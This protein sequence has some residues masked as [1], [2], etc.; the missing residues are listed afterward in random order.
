MRERFNPTEFKPGVY[1]HY[2]GNLYVALHIARHHDSPDNEHIGGAVVYVGD[3][4]VV[5]Y[6]PEQKTLNVREWDT[7]G[8]DSWCDSVDL[9]NGVYV[10]RFEYV[11]PAL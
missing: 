2:K 4:F 8:K 9:G 7:I 1:R 6:Y 3:Y 11:G 5:Y 10:P